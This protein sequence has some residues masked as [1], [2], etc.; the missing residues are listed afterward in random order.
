MNKR[1]ISPLLA[2]LLLG[3]IHLAQAAEDSLPKQLQQI[4][5]LQRRADILASGELGSDN[6]HLAKAR[7][8]LDLALSEYYESEDSEIVPA[9]T[10]QAMALLDALE[11]KQAD[12]SMDTP[13]QVKGSEAVRPDLWKIIAALKSNE[14]LS[15]GQR[16]VAEAEVHLVW[17]GHEKLESGW[18]QAQTYARSAEELL[19]EARK[20]IDACTPPAVAPIPPPVLEKITLSSDAMFEFG[21]SKL[22]PSYL[23]RLNRLADSIKK[24]TSLEVVDLIGHTDRLRSDGRQERNQILSEQRAESVRQYL[25]GRDIPA[26]KIN[27]SGAGSSQPLVQCSPKLSKAK[28]IACLRP[29]RRVEIILRG[30]R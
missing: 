24:E 5:S 7:T 13:M 29:N 22:E 23:W 10:G 1:K 12:I 26:D 9:A 16:S 2:A 6:Y 11:T 20:S 3:G 14:K 25:I 8:W 15:C 4:E 28:Q 19:R 18:A 17:A 30:T 27:A 21:S